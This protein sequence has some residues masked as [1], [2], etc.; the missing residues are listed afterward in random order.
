MPLPMLE[1]ISRGGPLVVIV[2]G[3]LVVWGLGLH[4]Q[5]SVSVV[6]R[7]P[8]GLPSLTVPE[9]D[10]GSLRAL[11]PTALAISLIGFIESIAVAK[12]LAIAGDRKLKPTRSWWP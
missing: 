10:W 11:L 12:A 3:T 1:A 8:P 6:G 7:V 4:E 9:L 5:A 2:A